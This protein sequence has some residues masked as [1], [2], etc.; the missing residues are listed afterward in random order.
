MD[1]REINDRYLK[2]ELEPSPRAGRGMY[3]CPACGSGNGT[4]GTGAVSVRTDG[5]GKLKAHCFVCGEDMDICDVVRFRESVSASDAARIVLQRY[6]SGSVRRSSVVEDFG[7]PSADSGALKKGVTP[8]NKAPKKE[9]DFSGYVK[10]CADALP[11]SQGERYLLGR[12]ILPATMRRFS[13]GYDSAKKAVVIP[14]NEPTT[15]YGWRLVSPGPGQ[16]PHDN[17]PGVPKALFNESAL[18]GDRPCFVVESPLCAVSLVQAGAPAAIALGGTNIRLLEGAIKARRPS[19]P[20]ILCLDNDKPGENGRRPGPEKQAELAAILDEMG[21]F[22]MESCV[23]GDYKDP[24][25]ALQNEPEALA[26]RVSWAVE[27]C[28][29]RARRSDELLAEEYAK[30]SAAG[31]IDAFVGGIA[32]SA[33]TPPVPTGFPGLDKLLDGGLYEGLYTLGAISSLGKTSFVLQICDQ[34]AKSGRDVLFFSLEMGRFELIAKSVSR[35]TY[36]LAK[37]RGMDSS[38]AKTTRGILSGKRYEQYSQEERRLIADAVI[39]YRTDISGKIWFVEGVGNI[40]TKEVRERVERHISATGRT[41]VV[42]VDYLQILAPADVRAS[43]K[44]STD[45]NVLELKRLSRDHKLTVIGISS[46][47]RDN[48]TEPINT[49]AFKESGAI[50]YGSDCLIGLQ[51]MGMEWRSGESEKNRNQRIRELH[52][53]NDVKAKKG[54]ALDIEIKI[55][56]NR[57]GSRGHSDPLKFWPMFNTF[58]EYPAGFEPVKEKTPFDSGFVL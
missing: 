33:S 49:A 25:E 44:Q 41:P 56:K 40:G 26:S 43:D 30:E 21:V 7:S 34:I 23:M 15:C 39:A 52:N 4:R 46:L 19:A 12:G 32:E 18:Q 24:N 16:H 53:E 2:E 17:P 50:E 45:R 27:E 38:K 10:A 13:L 47:N 1:L 14:Y 35:L 9:Q 54:E 48:Y 57:N 11:G 58:Q 37:G 22:Y 8:E 20:L 42:V 28:E 55:L 5:S 29:E 51:Y 36:Q 6:G 31:A 3:C